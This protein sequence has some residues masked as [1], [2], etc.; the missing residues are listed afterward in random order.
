VF[1]L[2][3]QLLILFLH[4]LQRIAQV[5]QRFRDDAHHKQ[6]EGGQFQHDNRVQQRSIAVLQ[7][8]A[9]IECRAGD[10]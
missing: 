3:C 4:F 7:R 5:D 6:N 10:D 2:L 1:H 8:E 9:L